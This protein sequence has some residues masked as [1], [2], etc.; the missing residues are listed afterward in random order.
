MFC[1]DACV[2]VAPIVLASCMPVTTVYKSDQI[3]RGYVPQQGLDTFNIQRLRGDLN[4]TQKPNLVYG[5]PVAEQAYRRRPEVHFS[6]EWTWNRYDK[7][8]PPRHCLALSGGGM[9]AATFSIGVLR[10]LAKNG[11]LAKIDVISSVSGGSYASSWYYAQALLANKRNEAFYLARL[12]EGAEQSPELK[13]L[14]QHS[15]LMNWFDY[16][17]A[18]TGNV[19]YLPGNL[20]LNGMFGWHANTSYAQRVYRRNLS[21][22][23]YSSAPESE[24]AA[25]NLWDLGQFAYREGMPLFIFNATALLENSKW[26]YDGLMSESIFEF[27]PLWFGSDAL[28]RWQHGADRENATPSAERPTIPLSLAI[29]ISGAAY[30]SEVT[31]SGPSQTVLSTAT[32]LDLGYYL[33]NPALSDSQRF[34]HKF[35]PFPS[36]YFH[37][38]IRDAE[39]TH[40][41]LTDGGHAE[42]LGLFSLVRRGCENIIV[43]DAEHDPNYEFE[44]YV[45]VRAALLREI[46]VELKVS[47]IE[48]KAGPEST[49]ESQLPDY[50]MRSRWK[51]FSNRPVMKGFIE[52]LPLPQRRSSVHVTYIKLAHTA[53]PCDYCDGLYRGS[54][55]G[56]SADECDL[57]HDAFAR[58]GLVDAYYHCVMEER[59][60]KVFL[61]PD[62]FPQQ[63]TMDQDFTPTQ[64]EAYVR[65]GAEV[66][67]NQ[68]KWM[69]EHSSSPHSCFWK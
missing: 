40:F 38:Y 35:L 55:L 15:R 65:L 61:R 29:A 19:I 51:Y 25:E 63:S 24:I 46:G 21:K 34:W 27:T 53:P 69:E 66:V 11:D 23:F 37:H 20:L 57:T 41:Y 6:D 10:Q 2:L 59:R 50:P 9:R 26:H 64:L 8:G 48:E 44:A 18:L 32:N 62:P 1:R 68:C 22:T 16:G 12:F 49:S 13:Q 31:A 5:E 52:A 60:T 28:G 47:E 33:P 4:S 36:Y 67:D 56:A 39:A 45:K 14:R 30:D 42:N 43:V 17:G 7:T 3:V 58:L 54:P